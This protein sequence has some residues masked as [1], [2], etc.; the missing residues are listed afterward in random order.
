MSIKMRCVG[1]GVYHHGPGGIEKPGDFGWRVDPTRVQVDGV[2]QDGPPVT[3]IAVHCPRFNV[4]FQYVNKV[5]PGES[6][7]KHYGDWDGKRWWAWDGN[8]ES[9]TIT[10]SIN[11]DHPRRCGQHMVITNGFISGTC[12]YVRKPRPAY[13]EET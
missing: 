12:E 9:P 13:K 10:P 8:F 1:I 4:C 2:W 11:C 6:A 3:Q 5:P 7:D